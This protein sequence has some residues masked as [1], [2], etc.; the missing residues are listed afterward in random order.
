[1][2]VASDFLRRDVVI[3]KSVACLFAAVALAGCC[4]SGN[5]CDVPLPGAPVAWDGL[6]APPDDDTVATERKPK[7]QP[8]TDAATRLQHDA[9]AKSD[10]KPL[11]MRERWAQQEAADRAAE[12]ALAKKL[13]ICRGC[14]SP[15]A[16]ADDET[17]GSVRR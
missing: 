13:V 17:T 2:A 14:S 3:L 5:G 16:R 8:K 6:G 9:A 11:T 4:M 1:M 15:P 10:A 7:R 12:G